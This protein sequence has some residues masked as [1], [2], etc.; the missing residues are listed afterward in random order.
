[1]A[2]NE[3]MFLEEYSR[4]LDSSSAHLTYSAISLY[5]NFNDEL[6]EKEKRFLKNHLDSCPSCS[7]KLLEVDEVENDGS[8]VENA[9]V[10]RLSTTFVR[11]SIA[12]AI[13]IVV[14]VSVVYYW[15]RAG[16][17]SVSSSSAN[18]SLAL[19]T[20][21]LE[22][23]AQNPA[24]EGFVG[25]TVRSGSG[26]RFVDPGVGDTISMPFTFRWEGGKAG[27]SYR[28]TIVD[29]RNSE[30][31]RSATVSSSVTVDTAL[32]QGLYYAKLEVNGN[33][34]KVD[35]FVIARRPL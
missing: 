2:P 14:G 21:D 5:R 12:A 13:L 4:F 29:N 27:V 6:S 26:V 16:R 30:H 24:L 15:N 7:K 20:P 17:G 9:N 8:E 1:M 35:K 10:L 34:E 3:T 11:F 25:R 19:E 32:K 23:F 18:N 31:F 28:L 33:L 22:R